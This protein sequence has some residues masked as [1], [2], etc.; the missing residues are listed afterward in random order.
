MD[1]L[2]H[3]VQVADK[4]V[5]LTNVEFKLL[6]KLIESPGRVLERDHLLNSVRGYERSVDTRTVDT[7]IRC[8]RAKLGS[9]SDMIESVRGFGYR[10]NDSPRAASL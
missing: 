10:F 6:A 5:H 7:H 3:V 1:I 9:S 2:R 8:L 4:A